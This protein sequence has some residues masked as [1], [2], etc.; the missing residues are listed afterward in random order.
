MIINYILKV[1][2]LSTLLLF[3]CFLQLS[4]KTY[5]QSISLKGAGLSL[6]DVLQEVRQQTGYEVFGNI[7]MLT[8]TKTV[9][10]QADHMP[11]EVFLLKVF[12]DQPVKYR[13]VNKTIMLE[14]KPTAPTFISIS[15]QL[16][17]ASDRAPVASASIRVKSSQ[18][19][20]STD[21][22]GK[23]AL[24]SLP[25]H[26]VLVISSVGFSPLEVPVDKL[27]AL[28]DG[29]MV[30]LG[31][32]VVKKVSGGFLIELAPAVI[33]LDETVVTAYGTQKRSSISGSIS[34]V[35]GT[36][37][38]NE[39][40]ASVDKMLQG[41]VAGLQSVGGSGQPGSAQDI[42]IRGIGSISAS[43]A[44]LFV[45]DG[46]PVNVGNITQTA[47]S[48]NT[49]AG[50]NPDDI[51]KI[52]VLKDASASSIYGSRAANGVII[53][54]T[55]QGKA[56]RPVIRL[57]AEFGSSQK[58]WM[59]DQNK[60]LSTEQWKELMSEGL[61]NNPTMVAQNSL[62]KENVGKYLDDTYR[63]NNGVNTDWIDQITRNGN[64]GQLNLSIDGGSDKS[65]YHISGGYFNQ[66]GV[67]LA[68]NFKRYSL[69]INNTQKVTDR[70]SVGSN[71]MVSHTKQAGPSN[72]GADDNPVLDAYFLLPMYS[73]RNPDGSVN[74]TAPD[75]P[76]SGINNPV[77][78]AEMDNRNVGILHGVGSV[79]G[80]VKILPGFTFNS[81]YGVDFN[82]AE[83]DRYFNPYYGGYVNENGAAYRANT[84]L[85]NWVWTN[86]FTYDGDLVNGDK[87][88]HANIKAGYEAQ[89]SSTYINSVQVLGMVPNLDIQV[90]SAGSTYKSVVGNNS[91]YAFISWLG[92]AD[93]T[94]D[95][96]YVLSGSFRRDG[97]S[98]FGANNRYGNFWSVGGAWNMD[99]ESWIKEWNV[100]DLLKLRGSYG[101]NGNAGIGDYDWRPL[102]AYS[103]AYNYIDENGSAPIVVGNNNL[104]WEINKPLDVGLDASVFKSRLNL[105]LDWYSRKTTKLLL[106]QPL[107]LTSGFGS[108][109]NNIGSMKNSGIE[110]ALSGTPLIIGDF[111]WE[112]NFN[113]AHNENKI[114]KLVD[115]A[116]QVSG[117]FIRREGQDFQSIYVPKWAGVDP[118]NGNPLW[119]KDKMMQAT[120]SNYNEAT[121]MIIGSA[122]PKVFG[123]FGSVFSYKGLSLD[124]LFYYNFGNLV[125][126]K[127]AK[128]TQSDGANPTFNK[129][130]SQLDRWQTPGQVTNVPKYVYGGNMASNS[131]SSRYFY[132]DDYIRLRNVSLGYKFSASLLRKAGISSA[133]LYVRG[134]NLWTWVKDKNLPFDPEMSVS[135]STNFEVYIPKTY[136][137]GANLSF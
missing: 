104:T 12:N 18:I 83:E 111:K 24:S 98:R 113:I 55:K 76:V 128:Y 82:Y 105:T 68:S 100:F 94:Y 127:Y 134:T 66:Q 131:T 48:S 136:T 3:G 84:R 69:N 29:S 14:R 30:S 6:M 117:V 109:S 21:V 89:K 22:Q 56:G 13:L 34:T 27:L 70:F 31:G 74:I 53:I 37:V 63:T 93:F 121:Y 9:S 20:T 108:F 114:L 110:L 35:S 75:F 50:L 57:D 95:R 107:S 130:T 62:T 1:M 25:D 38:E 5:S 91:N 85:F 8:D 79:Y 67:V 97:S 80:E 2:R 26:A 33:S 52:S 137:I 23:F 46:V 54:T 58:G 64:Q 135:G 32:S 43:S 81:K 39:P 61:L 86:M 112:A 102:Y 44:P 15:G 16:I 115:G 17:N 40:H 71:V 42:R 125:T 103:S 45:I 119:Y 59:S 47:T 118:D 51:D 36:V 78:I 96:K 7:A 19:G 133:K 49:L 106:A 92:I 41:R 90:P 65:T 60:P 28:A 87:P 99:Q 72:G 116:D 11:L 88:L 132:K 10:V 124:A 73:P 101:V 120:T 4:A 122:S 123:G 126:D 77:A 129:V